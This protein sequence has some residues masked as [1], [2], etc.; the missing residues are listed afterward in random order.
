VPSQEGNSQETHKKPQT[1]NK[2]EVLEKK[3][4]D[5]KQEEGNE[6]SVVNLEGETARR[7]IDPSL[8]H[9]GEGVHVRDTNMQGE[10]EEDMEVGE[11]N[12]E[13][14]EKACMNPKEGYIPTQQV[15]LLREAIIKVKK[16]KSLG[17][18]PKQKKYQEGK[19]KTFGD[20]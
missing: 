20:K 13:E 7:D 5:E 10:D 15:T 1:T 8:S 3:D 19:R 14:I 6:G 4:D 16:V 17:V 18:T 11:L 2:F 12:L 9:K